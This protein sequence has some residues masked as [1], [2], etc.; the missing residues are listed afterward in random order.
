[1]R[2]VKLILFFSILLIQYQ[3]SACDICGCGNNGSYVG[4]MPE[5]QKNIFGIRYRQNSLRTHVGNNGMNTYLTNKESYTSYEFWGSVKISKR[6]NLLFTLP[7]NSNERTS[8]IEQQHIN[9]LGDINLMGYYTL[10]Q[11]NKLTKANKVFL[12]SWRVS[13]GIKLPTGRYQQTENSSTSQLFTL[14]TG[15]L[16]FN[17]GS[18][19]EARIQNTGLNLMTNYKINTL[20]KFEYQ[21]GNKLQFNTQLYHKYFINDKIAISPNLGLQ[22]E[23]NDKDYNKQTIVEVSGGSL[24]NGSIGAEFKINN[25]LFGFNTQTPLSQNIGNKMIVTN[26]RNMVHLSFAF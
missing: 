22:L 20:N 6:F 23:I 25:I 19:Y 1:M 26:S 5:F 13:A 11:S 15:T 18:V 7:Y 21:Y 4:I 14:G 24:L 17:I 10:V 8:S 9:G 12:Q 2:K 3:V 16:D